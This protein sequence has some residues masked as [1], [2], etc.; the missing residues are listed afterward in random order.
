MGLLILSAGGLLRCGPSPEEKSHATMLRLLQQVQ[1]TTAQPQNAYANETRIQF[2]DSLRQAD[3][4]NYSYRYHRA[5]DLLRHG[6]SAAAASEL[7]TLIRLRA[8]GALDAY[9]NKEERASLEGYQALSYLRQGEQENCLIN[10]TA[11]SC[12]FPIQPAGFHQKPQGS[13]QAIALYTRILEDD[14]GRFECPLAPEYRLHD[15][16]AVPQPGT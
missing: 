2:F 15:S 8:T 9:L 11:A 7:D 16:R 13:Q 5:L 3:P 4:M 12:L 14:S 10:H 1:T 6:E